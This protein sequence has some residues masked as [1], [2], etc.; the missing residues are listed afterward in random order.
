MV[1]ED[2]RLA[3]IEIDIDEVVG[4]RAEDDADVARLLEHLDQIVFAQLELGPAFDRAALM[5]GPDG[6]DAPAATLIILGIGKKICC[7]L[8]WCAYMWHVSSSDR[9]D[10]EPSTRPGFSLVGFFLGSRFSALCYR[11]I[12]ST[13]AVDG[14]YK[15]LFL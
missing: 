12:S 2:E 13:A 7:V 11:L 9:L 3:A 1:G 14:S 6:D 8:L 10:T 4:F 15:L 5:A